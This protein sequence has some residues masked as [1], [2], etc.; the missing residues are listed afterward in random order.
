MEIRVS[1]IKNANLCLKPIKNAYTI[2]NANSIIKNAN[3]G[4]KNAN[5]MIKNANSMIRNAKTMIKNGN[6][7]L[8]TI[9]NANT[10][11]NARISGSCD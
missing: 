11:M 4:I 8:R 10:I 2:T 1:M 5:S 9:K 3:F 7:C 6:L